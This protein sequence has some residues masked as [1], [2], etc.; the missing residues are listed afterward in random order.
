MK[1]FKQRNEKLAVVNEHQKKTIDTLWNPNDE[2]DV[3]RQEK[4]ELLQ[5]LELQEKKIRSLEEEKLK[6]K[7]D[8]GEQKLELEKRMLQEEKA[9]FKLEQQEQTMSI[10]KEKTKHDAEKVDFQKQKIKEL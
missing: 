5:K 7:A 8:K 9:M 6:H 2:V 10:L 3:D 1:A 4:E